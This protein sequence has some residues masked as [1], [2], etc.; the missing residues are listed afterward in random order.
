MADFSDISKAE[1]LLRSELGKYIDKTKRAIERSLSVGKIVEILNGQGTELGKKT[2]YGLLR[3]YINNIHKAMIK[4]GYITVEVFGRGR[5]NYYISLLQK[6]GY[7]VNKLKPKINIAKLHKRMYNFL[8][9]MSIKLTNPNLW[10]TSTRV[11]V[12]EYAKP[13]VRK[14]IATS[15]QDGKFEYPYKGGRL[16][17]PASSTGSSEEQARTIY[18]RLKA[19]GFEETINISNNPLKPYRVNLFSY[20]KTWASDTQTRASFLTTTHLAQETGITQVKIPQTPNSCALCTHIDGKVF[21]LDPNGEAE[22]LT[23]E[24]PIHPNCKHQAILHHPAFDELGQEMEQYYEEQK[25]S[26]QDRKEVQE[27]LKKV[28]D[29]TD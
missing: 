27:I 22:Y 21:D 13:E 4:Y 19:I 10:A 17:I 6:A 25:F 12:L 18:H 15:F 26:E 9:S 11:T 7:N 14:I 1:K 16:V 3:R 8:D 2:I 28:T 23:N 29:T 20:C 5:I 24:L